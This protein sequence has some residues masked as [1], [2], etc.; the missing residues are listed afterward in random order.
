MGCYLWPWVMGMGLVCL[1]EPV[2]CE[3]VYGLWVVDDDV[4]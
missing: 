3:P 2:L 4:V 1:G